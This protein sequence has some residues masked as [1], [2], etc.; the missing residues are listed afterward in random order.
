MA[1]EVVGVPYEFK[2]CD[3]LAGE[4]MKVEDFLLKDLDNKFHL[5]AG[6]P[7]DQPVPQHPSH[8]RWGFLPQRVEGEQLSNHY[9]VL[10]KSGR[11]SMI[12]DL[13]LHKNFQTFSQIHVVQACAAYLA[14]KYGSNTTVYPTVLENSVSLKLFVN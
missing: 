2:K 9:L 5:A 13:F 4:N 3:L 7:G 12:H 10:H 11:D 1:A 6:V 14:N 8:Q